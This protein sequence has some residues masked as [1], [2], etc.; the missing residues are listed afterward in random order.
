MAAISTR[1]SSNHNSLL[2]VRK[3]F[4]V[5]RRQS[6]PDSRQRIPQ[7][8]YSGAK[9][10]TVQVTQVTKLLGA[11]MRLIVDMAD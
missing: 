3:V 11:G 9:L 10:V 6:L 4:P 2:I 7:P 5:T 8:S 1:D